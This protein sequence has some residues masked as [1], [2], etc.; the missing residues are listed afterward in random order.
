MIGA[1]GLGPLGDRMKRAVRPKVPEESIQNTV[2][3]VY[4]V[5]APLQAAASINFGGLWMRLLFE[6]AFYSRAASIF[7]FYLYQQ[8]THKKTFPKW[9]LVFF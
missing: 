9:G 6:S 4:T 2:C 1:Q 7:K 5:R 8:I 3:I